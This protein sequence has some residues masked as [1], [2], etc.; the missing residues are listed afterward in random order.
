MGDERGSLLLRAIR[1]AKNGDVVVVASSVFAADGGCSGCPRY[2]SSFPLSAL[3]AARV[4][5]RTAGSF[6]GRGGGGG[7][8]GLRHKLRRL[9][10]DNSKQLRKVFFRG[11]L[12]YE[13]LMHDE[14]RY[15]P[16]SLII[17]E[18]GRFIH[19]ELP[20]FRKRN[21]PTST[22]NLVFGFY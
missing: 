14:V 13:Q 19:Q 18:C 9:V 15:I 20:V 21:P 5:S 11:V 22:T 17:Y 6:G 8:A 10:R 2:E 7:E 12:S 1:L 3:Q 16:C 4:S